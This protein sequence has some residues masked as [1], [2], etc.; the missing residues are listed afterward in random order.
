M[1][2]IK[3]ITAMLLVLVLALGLCSCA[4]DGVWGLYTT[5][6]DE[7]GNYKSIECAYSK[8]F[9]TSDALAAQAQ[10]E[11]EENSALYEGWYSLEGDTLTCTFNIGKGEETVKAVYTFLYDKSADTLTLTSHTE[12]GE[13]IPVPENEIYTK[14]TE[15]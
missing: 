11:E 14:E 8:V 2:G 6:K 4:E 15:R 10:S 13:D 12:D 5:Q 1:Y 7:S 3:R 9:Y